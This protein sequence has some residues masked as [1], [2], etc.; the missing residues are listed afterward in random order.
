[1]RLYS[2][3]SQ[4]FIADSVHNRV[5][6]K[7]KSAYFD[8]YRREA[9]SGEVNAWRNSLRAV[10]QVLEFGRFHDHGVLL[11]YELPMTS[12][13]LDCMLTG[14]DDAST[15]GAVIVELKQWEACE[16]GD[17]DKVVTFLAGRDRDVLHP[18]VQVGQ[19]RT[20]LQDMHT[21][22]HD[23]PRAIGLAA[24]AYLHNYR[25]QANDPV[26]AEKF[27]GA[28][29]TCPLFSADDVDP[30]VEFLKARVGG[31]QG[32]ET[33]GRILESEYRPSKKLLDHVG[34]ILEGR[35][36]YVL[37]DEQMVAFNRVLAQ[38]AGGAKAAGKS[39]IVIRG[40]PGTGKSV[41]ALNLLAE[42]SRR[43]LVS[44]Y[45]TG[46]KAFTGT[47]RKIVGPRAANLCRFFNSYAQA[48]ANDVDVMICDEAHRIRETS[49][50]R[51]TPAAQKSNKPQI[52]ELLHAAKVLVC[53]V[54][55]RQVVRPGE[56]GS[57]PFILEKAGVA[58]ARAFDLKLE[59]QFRCNGS[60]GFIQWV[61][62][63]LEIERTPHVLWN[64][65]DKFEFGI[66]GSPAELDATIRRRIAKGGT[67]RLSAGFCW[68]WSDPKND[69]TLVADVVVGDWK[70]AW[71]AKS[72]AGRLA[73]GIPPENLWAF[74][75]GGVEQ[76]GCIY[77][78]QGFEF[79]YAG[80]IFGKDLVYR[81]GKGWVGQP[82][83]SFDTVVKRAKDGFLELVKNTYRVLL[84]RGMKGCFVY[85]Q[86]EETGNFF[87][88]RTETIERI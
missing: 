80:V 49:N 86:D 70:R 50:N 27:R 81:H 74:E 64:L 35:K 58:K 73:K 46:S 75:P 17:G 32:M 41:I 11:E 82:Q 42:L 43:G 2:G 8:A 68:P 14:R 3:P 77:T 5:T 47:L 16:D 13:R 28:I 69:G 9:V 36:E 61:N 23:G 20:Y 15:D 84:T 67:A 60:D 37:L 51:F 1:M 66:V 54:D 4:D 59:A 25:F 7:L 6:D 39:V 26:R 30:L 31:G 79:D 18:A 19:Y 76:V 87:T 72:T 48:A 65:K 88:S 83:V 63:T 40:G 10:S 33:L 78:A 34:G 24:C 71:N 38:A 45:V 52:D 21:A 56:I 85:F 12:R 62:N 29:E 55:D 53:F 57:A 22:F 44:H